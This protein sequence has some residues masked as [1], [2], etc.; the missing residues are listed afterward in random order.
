MSKVE[1]R[2]ALPH[3]EEVAAASTPDLVDQVAQ[4]DELAAQ[5]FGHLHLFAAPHHLDQLHQGRLRKLRPDS[6]S[7][8][9][10][11]RIRGM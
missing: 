1:R 4:G 3:E 8:R 5:R 9:S 2:I 10:A 7:A 11:A 6:P